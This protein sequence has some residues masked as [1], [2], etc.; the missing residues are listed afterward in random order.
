MAIYVVFVLSVV[1][2]ISFLGVSSKPSPIYGGFSL[3]V[4][5]GVGCGIVVCSGGSF[6]G[7][8]VFL[9]YLGGMLVVFGYTS[10]IA[11]EEYPE[12]WVSNVVVLGIFVIGSAIELVLVYFIIKGEEMGV[13]LDFSSKG[14]WMVYDTGGLGILSGDIMGVSALYSYGVWF[15]VVTGWSL[16]M[17]V[18][19][20]ME[21][22]RG[23]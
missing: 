17:C 4:A 9:I 1:F 13:V 14:D 18:I 8:I 23:N 2:V 10:A 12:A 20:V 19:I 3:I 22:T 6:L 5:G 16:L 15:I 7:L 21:I 11:I